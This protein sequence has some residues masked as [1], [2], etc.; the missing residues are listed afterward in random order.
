LTALVALGGMNFQAVFDKTD[1]NIIQSS[2]P[3]DREWTIPPPPAGQT[4]N[5]DFVNLDFSPEDRSQS[6]STT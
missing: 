6:A 2:K 1:E 3:L 5:P 4:F